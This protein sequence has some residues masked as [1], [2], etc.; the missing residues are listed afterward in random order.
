M[1]ND[2]QIQTQCEILNEAVGE[3]AVFTGSL[4]TVTSDSGS[5]ATHMELM[6]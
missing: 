6:S 1:M 5:G 4:A 3:I 2:L